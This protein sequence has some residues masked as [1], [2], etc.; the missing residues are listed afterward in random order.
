MAI[1]AI[2]PGEHW[3]NLQSL[4]ELRAEKRVGKAVKGMPRPRDVRVPV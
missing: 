2:H 1:V 3:M 4:Y